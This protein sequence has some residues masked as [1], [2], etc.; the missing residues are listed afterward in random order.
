[1]QITSKAIAQTR[2]AF[3]RASLSFT[4]LAFVALLWMQTLAAAA[5]GAPATFADLVEQVGGAVVN[6]TT[7][8][9][10]ATPIGPQGIVP[11]G[12]P[13][14]DL[15]RGPN[16]G[17]RGPRSASALG[18]G[19]VISED[20]YV[21]TNNHVIAG[22]DEIEVEFING[23]IFP[24]KIVGTDANIDIAVLKI[25]ADNPFEYVAFGNSDVARV[26]DWVMAMG[27]P[28]GQGFSVSAGIISA[29]NRELSGPYDDYI[30]TDAAINRGNSGGPLFNM[31]G[32]VIGVNTAIISPSGGSIGL[33]FSMASNTVDPVV[34]Q[35]KEY[36]EVR[37]GWLGV[38]IGSVNDEMAKALGLD[39]PTGAIIRD[40]FD[41][42]A[43]DAGLKTMDVIVMFDGKEVADSGALVRIVGGTPVGATVKTIVLRDGKRMSIDVVLGQRPEPNALA[44][45]D[46]PAEP[47]QQGLLGM[48]LS[49]ITPDMRSDM[50]LSDEV[51]G[52]LLLSV[53]ADSLA[54]ASGLAAGD[55]ITDAA[56]NPVEEIA[57]LVEQVENATD[58]GRESLLLLV[59]R[60][61]EPRF[62]VLKLN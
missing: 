51:T 42:P 2:P 39:E 25:D 10:M 54:A 22:A 44:Q 33:G 37:R 5:R 60:D 59:R 58:A 4:F 50:N 15:F 19:F 20:G 61:G 38:N 45:S 3:S 40:V 26:G 16:N 62:V 17:Q 21:V 8:T 55:V 57:D 36:G 6:I 41:G 56:Q 12:S 24:A 52:V 34:K 1:M 30:Q 14:E 29:R 46:K 18:A 27:N 23:D 49:E 43:K 31:D 35:L 13:F 53:E 32:E 48:Q 9:K 7:T 11:E 28:L 47:E